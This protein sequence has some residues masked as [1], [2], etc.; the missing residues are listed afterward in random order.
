M[1]SI[2]A[3][4]DDGQ[5]V[6]LFLARDESALSAVSEKYGADLKRIAANILDDE[7]AA[8]ECENDTYLK[9]WNSIPPHEPRTH[10]F[11]YLA[12]MIRALAIDRY[13]RL[14]AEKRSMQYAE[15]T[16]EIEVCIPAPHS[17]EDEVDSGLL[18]EQVSRFLRA[19][20]SEKRVVFLRRYW[21]MDSIADIAKHC[22]ISQSNVKT[23]LFRLRAQLKEHLEKE[24]FEI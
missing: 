7:G 8:E 18:S 6:D 1:N 4:P 12:R 22:G 10:L 13:R 19:L 11:A 2:R 24:G 21:Y 14:G 23:T 17:V 15:L 3:V 5:I 9:A 20:P 16:Q